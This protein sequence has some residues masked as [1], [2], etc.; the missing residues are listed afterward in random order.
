MI[1]MLKRTLVVVSAIAIILGSGCGA[2]SAV[3][4]QVAAPSVAQQP[5]TGNESGNSSTAGVPVSARGVGDQPAASPEINRVDVVYFHATQRCVTCLCFEEHINTVMERY[6]QDALQSGRLTYRVL[7]VQ[8]SENKELARKYGAVGSQ[9]FINVI[10][11]GVD[12]ITDIQEIWDWGCRSKPLEFE[13]KIR[14]AIE[15]GLSEVA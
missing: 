2:P 5:V 15:K 11:D 1:N 13:R 4:S 12:N 9:L 6:F 14:Q 3:D 10:K 7:D 8:K